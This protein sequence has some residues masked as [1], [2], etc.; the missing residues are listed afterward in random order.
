MDNCINKGCKYWDTNSKSNCLVKN[1]YDVYH[2]ENYD[3]N[4]CKD[5]MPTQ[6]KPKYTHKDIINGWLKRDDRNY[7]ARCVLYRDNKYCFVLGGIDS[8]FTFE[9]LQ[10]LILVQIPPKE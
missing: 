10:E 3:L 2:W 1:A 4:K 5:Y 6:K 7:W 9:E 8:Y